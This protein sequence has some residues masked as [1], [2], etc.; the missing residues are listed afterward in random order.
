M[1]DKTTWSALAKDLPPDLQKALLAFIRGQMKGL[2]SGWLALEKGLLLALPEAALR[3]AIRQLAS[4]HE[5]QADQLLALVVMADFNA[6]WAKLAFEALYER[7]FHQAVQWATGALGKM[8]HRNARL[9]G[10]VV[11][12]GAWSKLWSAL[13]RQLYDPTQPLVPFLKTI[14][15]N[16]AID[17]MR[18]NEPGIS[19]PEEFDPSDNMCLKNR[20]EGSY[21]TERVQQVLQELPPR[22]RDVLIMRL[23]DQKSDDEIAA[24]MHLTKKQVFNLLARAKEAFKR[25]WGPSGVILHKG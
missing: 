15:R 17:F 3:E 9:D 24:A 8:S 2:Q 25:H 20:E 13:R 11:A 22:Y 10:W 4:S 18:K 12:N 21:V 1:I 6:W 14:V 16:E 23:N 19:P 5:E 7:H